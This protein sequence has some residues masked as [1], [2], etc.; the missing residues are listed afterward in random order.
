MPQPGRKPG[1]KDAG[2]FVARSTDDGATFSRET[3]ADSRG[4]GACGCCG[5]RAAV[6]GD[7]TLQVLYRGARDN[8]GRD[9]IELAS[10][11][12][13]KNFKNHTLDPWEL[14][15]CPMSTFALAPTSGDTIAAWETA[16]RIVVARLT[17]RGAFGMMYSPSG[18]GQKHPSVAVAQ[19]GATLITWTE[20]TGWQRG[21]SLVWQ[22]LGGPSGPKL[23][24]GR[25]DGAIGTW[26][27]PTA[28]TRPDG[29]F[30]VIY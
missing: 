21:G 28:V 8:S 12:G 24:G 9:T 7:G 23:S 6:A 2:V 15:A 11:D 3:R 25:L 29:T 19:G 13:G 5:M 20:G 14:K 30:L 10:E 1:E 17:R 18:T 4:E 22:V 27:L 16:E 26:S